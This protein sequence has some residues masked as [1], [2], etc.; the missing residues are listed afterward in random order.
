MHLLNYVIFLLIGAHGFF[1]GSDF[2]V[3]PF[4]SFAV[5]S[6]AVVL[7]ILVFYKLPR[8]FKDLKTWVTD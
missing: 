6:Y 1:V 5:V 7:G 8:L 2:K 3:Q 4:F